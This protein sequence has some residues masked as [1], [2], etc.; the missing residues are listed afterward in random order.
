MLLLVHHR[1]VP[2][3]GKWLEPKL[4]TL[5][6]TWAQSSELEPAPHTPQVNSSLTAN[7]HTKTELS[8]QTDPLVKMMDKSK[9]SVDLKEP[10]A[11]WPGWETFSGFWCN[12]TWF[13][14]KTFSVLASPGFPGGKKTQKF[15]FSN[16]H[17]VG[18]RARQAHKAKT[19]SRYQSLLTNYSFLFVAKENLIAC[20]PV[21]LHAAILCT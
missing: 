9:L 8:A 14:D 3:R 16:V 12:C 6:R 21:V 20:F 18:E 5:L 2:H 10:T 1:W 19:Q 11:I 7:S 13:W 4:D 17:A 15:L